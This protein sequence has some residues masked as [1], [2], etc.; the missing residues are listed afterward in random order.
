[1]QKEVKNHLN[2]LWREQVVSAFANN[3]K[4]TAL[5][6][7]GLLREQHWVSPSGAILAVCP[8]TEGTEH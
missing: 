2:L 3:T 7:E 6:Q 5:A 1:M 8:C 4:K